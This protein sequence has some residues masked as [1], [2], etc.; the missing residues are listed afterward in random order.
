MTTPLQGVANVGW[1]A[2]TDRAVILA[3]L[4]V[5]VCPTRSTNLISSEPPAVPKRISCCSPGT[6]ADSHVV[7]HGA[8]SPLATRQAAGV[9]TLVVLTG[10]LWSTVRVLVTL[11]LYT[12]CVGVTLVSWQ[13]LAHRASSHILALGPSTTHTL[14]TGVSP[15]TR[16]A[17]GAAYVSSSTGAHSTITTPGTVSI[18]ATGVSTAGVG[19]AGYIRVSNMLWRTF[20][21]SSSSIVFTDSSLSTWAAGARVK[22]AVC[23][24]I[25]SVAWL[26]LA[27]SCSARR[28]AVSISSTGTGGAWLQPTL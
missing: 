12:A 21:D 4:T 10:A 13:T 27:H 2:A 22:Q 3:N 6:P 14:H 20:T 9:H 15:A 24:G 19:S 7:L 28:C 17:V 5:S 26:T 18:R 8:V 1:F 25:T 23:V 16:P 11:P